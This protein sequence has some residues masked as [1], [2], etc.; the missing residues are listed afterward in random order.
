[1][2]KTR[3]KQRLKLARG[4]S[5]WMAVT[6]A[7]AAG[8]DATAVEPWGS[9]Y[10]PGFY[11]DFHMAI[12]PTEGTFLSQFLAG[13]EAM[14]G[15]AGSVVE[16]PGIIHAPG[17]EVL[18]GHF[19]AA[20]YPNLTV[21]WDHT[22]GQSSER[23]GLGDFY[24]VPLGISWDWTDL[25]VV[26]FQGV[27]APTGH[28]GLNDLNNSRNVWT[29]DQNV[30]LTWNLPAAMELNLDVGFMENV[31]NSATGYD[32]GDEF[33]LDYTVAHYVAEIVGLGFTGSYYRQIT[34]DEAPAGAFLFPAGSAASIGPAVYFSP[35]V[36]DR[37][38]VLSLKWLH[39]VYVDGRPRQD[40]LMSR[41]FLGF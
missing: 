7:V 12:F 33:H 36:G 30:M 39:E 28:F 31:G 10:L 9:N 20:I 25:H 17:W 11:G 22:R 32:S 19:A 41:I 13:V 38:V 4:V 35:H 6:L 24:L 1:M 2:T 29:F 8:S 18:G 26:A 34:E 40:Y 21:S 27:V 15:Q 14:G 37:D 23:F 3:C 16:M 5:R